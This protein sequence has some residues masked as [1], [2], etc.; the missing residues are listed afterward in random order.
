MEAWRIRD[1]ILGIQAIL[2]DCHIVVSNKN[3]EGLDVDAN[4]GGTGRIGLL[5]CLV[6]EGAKQMAVACMIGQLVFYHLDVIQRYS[7]G[8][9]SPS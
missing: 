1:L 2:C 9:V 3:G 7:I 6:F 8:P 4:L 5:D